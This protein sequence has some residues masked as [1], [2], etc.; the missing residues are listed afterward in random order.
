MAF[1]WQQFNL[2]LYVP[3]FFCWL[4]QAEQHML[5]PRKVYK[6]VVPQDAANFFTPVS[7]RLNA[8]NPSEGDI[9]HFSRNAK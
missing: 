5:K 9:E 3:N 6:K 7:K 4:T 2:S 8:V 1:D